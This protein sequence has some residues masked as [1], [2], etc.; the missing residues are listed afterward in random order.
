MQSFL[1][2][3]GPRKQTCSATEVSKHVSGREGALQSKSEDVWSTTG[4]DGY[5]RK[6]SALKNK[7]GPLDL[8]T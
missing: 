5:E 4:R 7:S 3:S 6:E 1:S 2:I 8:R